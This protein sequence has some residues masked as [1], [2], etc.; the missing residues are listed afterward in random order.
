MSLSWIP[1][2]SVFEIIHRV[3]CENVIF[4]MENVFADWAENEQPK[5]LGGL[6]EGGVVC[7][8]HSSSKVGPIHSSSCL[9][10]LQQRHWIKCEGS[11]D[12]SAFL[13]EV[14]AF[15]FFS[16]CDDSYKFST[17]ILIAVVFVCFEVCLCLTSAFSWNARPCQEQRILQQCCITN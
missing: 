12:S 13:S 16:M 14:L 2:W 8:W 10:P 5:V 3:M 17:T 9:N 6:Q 4:G 1:F 7:V 15:G 11:L